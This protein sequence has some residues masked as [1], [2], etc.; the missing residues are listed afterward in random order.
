MIVLGIE[1]SCDDCS[2]SLVED[3]FKVLSLKTSSQVEA[4]KP[5]YGVVP[6]IASRLHAQSI[7]IT[8]EES[9]KEA[10]ITPD[11][12]D[13]IAVTNRPGLVGSLTVGVSF[14]KGLSLAL[15]KPI[16]GID[17]IK[18]HLYSPFLDNPTASLPFP[19]ISLLVSGGHTLLAKQNS[20]E[21]IEI[22]GTTLDDACGEAFD[23]VAK[24]YD[25]G[26][27]GGPILDKMAQTGDEKAYHF[28]IANTAKTKGEISFNFSF[29]GLK[30]A[31]IHQKDKFLKPNKEASLENLVASFQ[32]TAIDS[33]LINLEKAIK[34]TGI[35]NIVIAGGVASNSY[36]R[37]SMQSLCS[38]L[39]LKYLIPPLK[40]CTDNGAM[41]GGLG[42][43]T[44]LEK[45]GD[46]L[47]LEVF[48]RVSSYKYYKHAKGDLKYE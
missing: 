26:F 41:V 15:N 40:Y 25:L 10:Q 48:S 32:K 42:Y 20:L 17:H 27:P 47:D 30:T 45:G 4:H 36:L 7:D 24:Y 21:D 8:F 2:I 3:G 18:A 1:S 6:E 39:E 19:F 44:F 29:S 9:L 11:K 35:K 31:V 37:K 16:I 23:K 22:L 34:V 28:P 46:S 43:H 14:A 13:I 5:F 12:I 38:R 33:L